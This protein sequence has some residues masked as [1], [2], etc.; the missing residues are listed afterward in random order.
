MAGYR[1]GSVFGG[2]L[3]IGIGGLFLYANLHP[4]FSAWPLLA[5]FWPVLIIFWGLGKLV[6]YLMLRGT[7]EAPAAS[8]LTGGD[9]FGLILLLVFGSLVS[10]SVKFRDRLPPK[11]FGEEFG[12][13]LGKEYEFTDEIRQ[14]IPAPG[15]FSLD[16][17]RGGVTVTG[18][19]GNEL[20]AAARK[21]VCAASEDEA[22]RIRDSYHLTFEGHEGTYQLR[23][24]TQGAESSAV[25]VDLDLQVPAAMKQIRLGVEHGDVKV[26]NVPGDVNLEVHGGTVETT[27][28][29]GSVRVEGK[30][31]EIRVR[32]VKGGAHVEG[33]YYGPIEFAAIGGAVEYDS[34]RTNFRTE[35]LPGQLTMEGGELTL[36]GAPAEVNLTTRDYEVSVE[37]AGGTLRLENRNGGV[38]IRFAKAP[39]QPI[40]VSNR[41]GGIELTLP[42]ATGFTLTASARN[43]DIES[44]FT[45]GTLELKEEHGDSTLEGAYGNGRVPIQLSTSHGTITLR[46]TRAAT[47]PAPGGN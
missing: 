23:W 38:A 44:D 9:I 35:R 6:D 16:N 40:E 47:G 34:S 26:T 21:R 45:G 22:Q 27:G 3:L 29:G 11:I 33:S 25:A 4:E 30:G 5:K 37:D 41:S 10:E 20:R 32:E 2:L 46:R 43:G 42:A 13:L 12:C 36:R 31:D 15:T 28:I 18:V 19:T 1:R 39:S 14:A 7:P 24:E 17:P 8:R